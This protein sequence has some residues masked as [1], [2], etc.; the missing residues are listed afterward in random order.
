VKLIVVAIVAVG[1]TIASC[2]KPSESGIVGD[3]RLEG[4]PP[5][6][7]PAVPTSLPVGGDIRIFD[8]EGALRAV[9]HVVRGR[10]FRV[11]VAPGQYRVVFYPQP[12]TAC[13]QSMVTVKSGAFT[14]IHLVC[15]AS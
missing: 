1:L 11:A 8:H 13:G 10:D 3:V 6:I 7:S 9:A 4:G 15:E 14:A 2:S 5:P 12:R